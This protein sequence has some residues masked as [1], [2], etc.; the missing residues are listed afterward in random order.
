VLLDGSRGA[1]PVGVA[2]AVVVRVFDQ[3]LVVSVPEDCELSPG[4]EVGLGISHPCTTFDKWR[5]LPLVDA[6]DLI[7]D[8]VRTFF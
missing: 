5:W 3:H 7:V 8:V 6:D 4:D 2:G 1:R